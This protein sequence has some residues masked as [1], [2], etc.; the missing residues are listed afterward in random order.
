MKMKKTIIWLILII[1]GAVLV[2]SITQKWF[3]K[4]SKDADQDVRTVTVERRDIDSSIRATGIIKPM[5]GADVRVGSRISGIVKKLHVNIGDKVDENELLAELDATEHKARYDQAMA[6]LNMTQAELEYAQLDLQRKKDLFEKNFVSQRELDISEKSF[7]LAQLKI[8]EAEANLEYARVQLRYTEIYAPIAGVVSSVTTQ[9]G[10]TVAAS[11]STPTFVTIIDLER[12]EVWAYVDETDIG[13]I[14]VGQSALFSVDTYTDTDF[15]GEVTAI[16]PKAEIQNNVVNYISV[17]KII[18]NEEKIL[19]PEMTTSVSIF[20]EKRENVLTVP[21]DAI[22]RS[23][24]KRYVYVLENGQPQRRWVKTGWNDDG[25]T[26]ITEGLDA[27]EKVVIGSV[28]R[29]N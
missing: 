28:T 3:S 8:N 17:I 1:I 5:V 19:R 29:E 24:G 26:E 10:E 7:H 23:E 25:Y 21:K 4:S 20:L 18:S 6:E 14:Q 15:E 16:Y 22:H 2:L 13:R 12:L 27:N 9:E 11:F